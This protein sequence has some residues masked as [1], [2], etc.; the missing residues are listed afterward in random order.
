[1]DATQTIGVIYCAISLICAFV[2]IYD[3]VTIASV[4]PR[5]SISRYVFYSYLFAGFAAIFD[6]AFPLRQTV[7]ISFSPVVSYILTLAYVMC[8][9]LTGMFW[10][11]YSERK[12][13]SWI[14]R[15][16]IRMTIF[17]LPLLVMVLLTLS[18][19][20]T[21]VYFYFEGTTYKRGSLFL[22][23]S[24]LLLVYVVQ[25]GI[26]S[27]ISMFRK[28]N[29][30]DR[31]ELR[32]LFVYAFAYLLIQ[33]IQLKL[34]DIFPY[35]SV[36]TMIIFII[37]L[38]LSM[39]E[40]IGLD[41]LTRINNRYAVDRYLGA[42]MSSNQSFEIIIM[43]VDKFKTIND[44]YGHNEGDLALQYVAEA[45]KETIPKNCFCAR[46]GR[47]EFIIINND[48]EHSVFDIQEPL[49]ANIRAITEK[50]HCKYNFTVSTGYAVNENRNKSIPDLLALADKQLYLC[51]ESKR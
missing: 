51:K 46:W 20:F 45:L 44:K 39:K 29:Y 19:P 8:A 26:K 36:G 1:M 3:A 25:N 28:E 13:N 43:D 10:I 22:I 40:K 24:L 14:T 47:D 30:V 31:H 15:T 37:F 50:H 27:L 49:N 23:V 41:P 33:A 21:H 18:T 6:C 11:I 35:R 7:G 32:R 17:M 4:T 5:N 2:L 34:P 9:N 12:Q 48:M 16:K 42:M 38:N